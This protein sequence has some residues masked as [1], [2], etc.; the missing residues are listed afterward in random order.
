MLDALTIY[1]LYKEYSMI[2][3]ARYIENIEYAS[4]LIK[5]RN[6]PDDGAVVECG[7]W[8]GGM[9][10][11]FM[12][13]FGLARYYMMF[14]SFEGLPDPNYNDGEDALWWKMHPEHPRYF[15]NC[16][17]SESDVKKLFDEKISSSKL[18]IV[19][20]YFKETLPKTSILPIS[21]LH[22]DCDWYDS[23][24][25]CLQRLWDHILPGGAIIIDDYF[26]WEG[27]RRAV[28]DFL[29]S[30]KAREAI[31]RV[32]KN[33]GALIRKLGPWELSE[34]PHLL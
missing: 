8:R 32:G 6:F 28:H 15:N 10:A 20:G 13:V 21:F 26:D 33:G 23:N 4:C 16:C 22:L 31:E 19:K 34:T 25:V 24:L 2:P 1:D 7:V 27:C 12:Q 5:K 29:S 3:K 18:L 9:V 14:D 30:V 11:G 17:A